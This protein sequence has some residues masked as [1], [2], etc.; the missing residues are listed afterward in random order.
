M[1]TEQSL[2]LQSYKVLADVAHWHVLY[3]A[4][5]LHDELK[6][7]YNPSQPRV[8]AGNSTGGQW[9]SGGG[10][11]GILG[12]LVA[13]YPESTHTTP[14]IGP[15]SIPGLPNFDKIEDLIN[16]LKD[17]VDEDDLRS[18]LPSISDLFGILPAILA[19]ITDIISGLGDLISDAIP[20]LSDFGFPDAEFPDTISGGDAQ[21]VFTGGDGGDKLPGNVP[22]TWANPDKFNRHYESHGKDF[23][24]PSPQE[25]SKQDQDFRNRAEIEK[26][27]S[28]RT[29]D[30]YTKVY[31]PKTNTF[32]VYNPEGK[33]ETFYKPTSPT[34]YQR[35]VQKVVNNGGKIVNPTPESLPKPSSGGGGG[36]V[37]G[38]GNIGGD[39]D[40]FHPTNKLPYE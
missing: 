3:Q 12:S 5:L 10:G 21:D 32:G 4:R 6:A 22:D 13:E 24:Y 30:G 26:L 7:G 36:R 35:E 28:V 33:T 37:S 27:P 9:T 20:S 2:K 23:N 11:G 38:A 19:P 39:L 17:G 1:Y 25:Y 16:I 40:I 18:L 34:Y 31:D 15:G 8:P 29:Q 14:P